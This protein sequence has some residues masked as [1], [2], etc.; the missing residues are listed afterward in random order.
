MK[1]I[2]C[3][4]AACTLILAG[5]SGN[6]APKADN[7]TA[8]TTT[9]SSAPKVAEVKIGALEPL[10]GGLAKEGT[11]MLNAIQLAVD[12]VNQAGGIRSL[13]GAKVVLVKADHEGKPE[14][15][16]SETQRLIHEGVVG[17]VGAYSSG[18]ALPATQEAEKNK[19]P[20]IIDIGVVDQLTER[21]FKYTFRIQPPAKSMAQNFLTYFEE[22]NKKSQVKLKTAVL[23]HEDSVFGSG[24]AKLIK[25]NA[26]SK[27]IEV[28]GEFAYPAS[29]IDLSDVVNK[30]KSL[31][32]DVVIATTYLQDGMML[33]KGLKDANF[34]PKAMLGVANGAFSNENFIQNEKSINQYYMDTNYTINPKSELA[35]KVVEAY[36]AQYKKRIS[37]NAAYSYTAAKVMI[38]AVERAGSVDRDKVRDAIAATNM[39]E[40]ILPQGPIKFSSTGQNENAQAVLN[41]IIDGKSKVVFPDTFK[42]ADPVYPMP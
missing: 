10:T 4:M 31:K 30:I 23:A 35:N 24:I 3:L 21:G 36:Q 32:P 11:D 9:T 16:V 38:D 6:T 1:K 2:I 25:E 18:V 20:F 29:S 17:I 33:V 42:E 27:G 7:G 37:A 41:Q 39:T 26:A 22:L 15:G 12:E 34:K 19:T 14:K 5:C 28:L 40:H 8:T 13:G